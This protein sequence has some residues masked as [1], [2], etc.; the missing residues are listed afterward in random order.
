VLFLDELAEFSRPAL[1][2]LRQ[3]IEEGAIRITRSQRTVTFPARFMLVAATNPCPCGHLGDTRRQCACPSPALRRYSTKL[4]GPLMDRI[5]MIV[6]VSSPSRQELIAEPGPPESPAVRARVTEARARQR[7]RLAGSTARC[8][9]EL[10][11]AEVRLVCPLEPSARSALYAAHERLSLSVRGHDRVLRVARTLADLDGRDV[12]V[13][14]D[15][16][17]AVAYRETSPA[18]LLAAAV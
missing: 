12:I 13:R 5:D 15:V 1:E 2:A 3:P 11:A 4:S 10:S 14:A 16:A 6:E 9:G 18:D 8:N 7:R 17:Q